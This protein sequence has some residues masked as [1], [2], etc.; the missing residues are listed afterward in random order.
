MY[1]KKI[2]RQ[3]G[4]KAGV[5]T[6]MVSLLFYDFPIIDYLDI[7]NAWTFYWIIISKKMRKA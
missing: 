1:T 5:S 4:C 3:A 6:L 7:W 2:S